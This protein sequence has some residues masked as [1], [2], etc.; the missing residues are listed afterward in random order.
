MNNDLRPINTLPNFKRFCM[1]I[2]ELPTS[3]LETMTY[4]EMLVWFTEYMKNTIIP[5]IN[6]NGLAVQELQDKYIE[7][8]SY[9]DNYF[10]NLDVQEEINNKLDAMAESG[11]LTDIIA[12]YLGLAG[13][14]VFN[15]VN[16]MKQATNLVN[17]STCQTLGFNQINDDG[18]ATY[19]I[20]SI[21]ND[22]VIDEASIIALIDNSLIAELIIEND[23]VNPIQ[24]GAKCNGVDDD[25]LSI[26]KAINYLNSKNGGTLNL[27]DNKI[28]TLSSVENDSFITLKN[29][30]NI[31]GKSILK[32]KNNYGDFRFMFIANEN[33]DNITLKDFTIDENTTNNPKTNNTGQENYLRTIFRLLAHNYNIDNMIIENVT[34]NDCIGVWQYEFEGKC[35][36]ISLDNC[37]I[38]YNDSDTIPSY[39]RTS[40]YFGVNKGLIKNCKLNGSTNALTGI[41]LHGHNITCENNI[42]T[43]YK[44]GFFIVND[45]TV[46]YN[47]ENISLKVCS[48]N[49]KTRSTPVMSWLS[50]ENMITNSIEIYDNF[51]HVIE[52]GSGIGNYDVLGNGSLLKNYKI[53]NNT[54]ISDNEN[55]DALK[56]TS[57]LNNDFTINN[58]EIYDNT[59]IG[60]FKQILNFAS[61]KD[62]TFKINTLEINN[63]KFIIDNDLTNTFYFI[64]RKGIKNILIKNNYFKYNG[65]PSYLIRAYGT[66]DD[67][68]EFNVEDNKISYNF[69]PNYIINGDI[70]ITLKQKFNKLVFNTSNTANILNNL[71]CENGSNIYDDNF[72]CKKASGVWLYE[73]IGKDLRTHTPTLKGSLFRL[74][75]NTDFIIGCASN[76]GYIADHIAG[77]NNIGEWVS[78]GNYI[79][80]SLTINNISVITDGDTNFKYIGEKAIFSKMN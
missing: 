52:S 59:F 11:Q 79:Y 15:N 53:Y 33:I 56:F 58:F 47:T 26:R 64:L 67:E 38:N 28:Y 37:T 51:L 9:V 25:A 13:M 48:N 8:K 57:T 6:N 5:T 16:D 39:D 4:Y 12:Q 77:N 22:D 29:K 55:I 60:K 71:K 54:V 65:T 63:N 68:L 7:L 27:L 32:V 1:T 21:T 73:Y 30:C 49:V 66:K 50:F 75:N 61:N 74:T 42:I 24:F 41:E 14:L 18:G 44:N 31:I 78:Y 76:N 35:D 62:N 20:R 36:N 3:Y 17:G 2:G 70:S 10:D 80:E 40:I 19:K 46:P 43:D 45:K 69:I 23:E 34:I 72:N